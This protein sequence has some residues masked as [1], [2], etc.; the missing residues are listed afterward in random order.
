MEYTE[1]I[2]IA[3]RVAKM[4]GDDVRLEQDAELERLKVLV[5]VVSASLRAR[6]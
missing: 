1:G 6:H 3:N 2:D 4:H 5:Q